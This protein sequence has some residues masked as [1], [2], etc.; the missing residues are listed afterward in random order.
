MDSG[1]QVLDIELFVRKTWIPDSNR[2]WDPDSL[3]GIPE[4]QDSGFH[5]QKFPDSAIRIPYV[6]QV[7]LFF[8]AG[9][10]HSLRAKTCN[11]L[12]SPTP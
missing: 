4:V 7:F 6:G 8:I 3:S 9:G 12:S 1:L 2:W 5:K 11:R 10:R